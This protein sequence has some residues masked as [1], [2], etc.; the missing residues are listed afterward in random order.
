MSWVIRNRRPGKVLQVDVQ[1]I[2]NAE[3]D[4]E[5]GNDSVKVTPIIKA[6]VKEFDCSVVADGRPG[7]VQFHRE[8]T[9][10]GATSDNGSLLGHDCCVAV[11]IRRLL[12][13]VFFVVLVIVR[14]ILGSSI[15]L[16]IRHLP[17][18]QHPYMFTT[19]TKSE[20]L[21]IDSQQDKFGSPSLPNA[22]VR[23]GVRQ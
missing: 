7:S 23:F 4:E 22:R 2:G 13:Y 16:Q 8:V 15:V 3:L 6:S 11:V 10:G 14:R 19:I 12:L 9:L 1:R 20:L 21:S 18:V 5:F 17:S